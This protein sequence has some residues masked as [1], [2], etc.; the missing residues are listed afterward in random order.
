MS[1]FVSELGTFNEVPAIESLALFPPFDTERPAEDLY[2]ELKRI[3]GTE[4]PGSND[5]AVQPARYWY[6]SEERPN[7]ALAAMSVTLR[8]ALV[9]A[10][11]NRLK[12]FIHNDVMVFVE[13]GRPKVEGVSVAH[14]INT[15]FGEPD[16]TS[17]T[18]A[19]RTFGMEKSYLA[20]YFPDAKRDPRAIKIG[21]LT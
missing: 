13:G 10:H 7:K 9:F 1:Q 21:S 12:D 6:G 17:L 5:I 2:W 4:E 14:Y 16:V 15:G 8:V 18:P 11:W 20:Y 19:W 3:A